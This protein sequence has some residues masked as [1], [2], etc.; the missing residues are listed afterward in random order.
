VCPVFLDNQLSIITMNIRNGKEI[1]P[2]LLNNNDK[3]K[4]RKMI[5]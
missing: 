1:F 2:A 3:K 5:N 4:L